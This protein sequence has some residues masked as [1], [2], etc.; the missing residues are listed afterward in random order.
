MGIIIPKEKPRVA[1]PFISHVGGEWGR[2][3]L[4]R[5]YSK[6]TEEHIPPQ[7]VGNTDEWIAQSYLTK[8]SAENQEM[9]HGR[10]FRGG[11]RLKTLCGDC[12][13][14]LG[15]REDKALADFFYEVKKLVEAPLLVGSSEVKV[16]A[17]PNLIFK[18]LFAHI[19]SAN[20]EGCPCDFDDEAREIFLNKRPLQQS[21][22]NLFYWLY[23]GNEIAVLRNMYQ[24]T[25]TPIVNVR[26]MFI[27]KLF[28]LAFLFTRESLFM[29]FP[30]V[31]KFFVQEDDDEGEVPVPVLKCDINPVWPAS[32]SDKNFIMTGANTFGLVGTRRF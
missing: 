30:N 12:N 13:S 17:K 7:S 24:V 21:S 28:P 27:L 23:L 20:A 1:D 25:W 11:F 32:T 8:V 9:Y 18:G 14:R 16:P 5:E 31:R 2:C 15:G 4:C 3:A 19:A 10:Q 29:G 22:W 26:P 6:L